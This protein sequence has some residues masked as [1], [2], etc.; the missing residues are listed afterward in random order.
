MITAMILYEVF[1]E[2]MPAHI[3]GPVWVLGPCLD[4]CF[5]GYLFAKVRESK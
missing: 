1:I 3:V 5:V 4:I 2:G